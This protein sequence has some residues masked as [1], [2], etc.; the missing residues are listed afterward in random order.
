MKVTIEIFDRVA[1]K[2]N[3]PCKSKE[4]IT[5]Q[6]I[7][8]AQHL[9]DLYSAKKIEG[10]VYLKLQKQILLWICI[11]QWLE[12]RKKKDKTQWQWK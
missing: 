1:G 3:I 12:V 8:V 9:N 10:T 11:L 2:F 5:E 4:A 7:T 6:R